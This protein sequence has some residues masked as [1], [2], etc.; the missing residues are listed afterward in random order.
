MEYAA[1]METMKYIYF[2]RK[3]HKLAD[4]GLDVVI[5]LKCLLQKGMRRCELDSVNLGCG[6]VRDS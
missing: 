1:G 4:I 3:L 2:P 5:I 6:V